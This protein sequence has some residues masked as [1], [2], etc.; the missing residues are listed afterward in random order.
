MGFPFRAVTSII[1]IIQ[2]AEREK[3]IQEP[4]NEQEQEKWKQINWIEVSEK[5]LL[6]ANMD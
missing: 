1:I 4:N 2:R 6:L 5:F 3:R